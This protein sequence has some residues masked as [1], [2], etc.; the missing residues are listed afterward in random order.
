M[1]EF[2]LISRTAEKWLNII[3]QNYEG[4][5]TI[6]PVPRW[7]DYANILEVPTKH[8]DFLH[9]MQGGASKTFSKVP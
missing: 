5:I 9:F 4:N 1:L 8:E 7:S 3:L 6:A 2:G